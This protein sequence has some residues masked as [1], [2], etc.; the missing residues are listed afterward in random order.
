MNVQLFGSGIRQ[1]QKRFRTNKGNKM[2]I[3]MATRINAFYP[4]QMIVDDDG[5][6]WLKISYR[7]DEEPWRNYP[8][9]VR[10]DNDVYFRMS[11]N[12]DVLT[13]SYAIADGRKWHERYND[14]KGELK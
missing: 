14:I 13:V 10:Y 9:S 6:K 7:A 5:R 12:S 3:A 11:Y 2:K 8:E 1:N 4:D